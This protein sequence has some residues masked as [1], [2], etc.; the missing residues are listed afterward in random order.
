MIIVS[1]QLA[2]FQCLKRLCPEI[3]WGSNLSDVDQFTCKNQQLGWQ[4]KF[5]K[6]VDLCAEAQL[7]AT[8]C[9]FADIISPSA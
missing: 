6:H 7:N 4:Q 5:F 9:V 2:Q 1:L 8:V 3:L